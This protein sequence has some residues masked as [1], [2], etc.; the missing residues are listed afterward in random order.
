M[1]GRT[2]LLAVLP[3]ALAS[4]ACQPPA[5]ETG[6]VRDEHERVTVYFENTDIRFVLDNFADFTGKSFILGPGVEGN[7]VTA[8]VSNQ[9]WDSALDAIEDVGG[10]GHGHG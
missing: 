2:M 6:T 3:L 5:Q 10:D 4:T 1:N 8:S 7:R 9:P